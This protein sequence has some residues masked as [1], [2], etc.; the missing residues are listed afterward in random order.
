MDTFI[1]DVEKNK[2]TTLLDFALQDKKY[3]LTKR[4]KMLKY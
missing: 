4:G 2:N 1:N 3:S